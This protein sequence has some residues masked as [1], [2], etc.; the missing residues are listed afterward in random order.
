MTH[1][2]GIKNNELS[3]ELISLEI[4]LF[5][6]FLGKLFV[7]M[8]EKEYKD[9]SSVLPAHYLQNNL[10]VKGEL[11]DENSN[12][13][14]NELLNNVPVPEVERLISRL[15]FIITDCFSCSQ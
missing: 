11:T 12:G 8:D 5:L 13:S 2:H 4:T 9:F 10:V 6:F 3:A 1:N 7:V 15:L 14:V